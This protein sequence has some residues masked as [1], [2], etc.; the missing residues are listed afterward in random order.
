MAIRRL[1]AAALRRLGF[2]GRARGGALPPYQPRP[3]DVPVYLSPGEYRSPRR[4]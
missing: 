2:P 1:L 3:D 4:G